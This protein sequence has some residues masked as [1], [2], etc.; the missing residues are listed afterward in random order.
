MRLAWPGM[1]PQFLLADRTVRV[2]V[3]Y[4]IPAQGIVVGRVG[5][6]VVVA[7][8][9]ITA[10]ED[11]RFGPWTARDGLYRIED[12]TGKIARLG[13]GNILSRVRQHRATRV[14][15]PQR[16]IVAV[17]EARE[18][19]ADE[20]CFLEL[21]WAEH[22]R[23]LGHALTSSMFIRHFP[24]L[25]LADRTRLDQQLAAIVNL[26]QWGQRLLDGDLMGQFREDDRSE[27]PFPGRRTAIYTRSF[28]P[29]T[30]LR[31]SDHKITAEAVV[32]QEGVM[33]LVGSQVHLTCSKAVGA[34]FGR[35]HGEFLEAVLPDRKDNE[36]GY[37][38]AATVLS[39]AASLLKRVTAGRNHNADGWQLQ[40]SVR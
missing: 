28:S 40:A 39:T 5:A 1:T 12:Q 26:A 17:P 32:L 29:G 35:L 18:W 25:T 20:R 11:P 31:F 13:Q 22:W 38:T 10:C 19:S 6:G 24:T 9:P 4:G 14:V 16:L 8:L 7:M 34:R 33:L 15:F 23:S 2:L 30:N 27:R 21:N 3:P 36:T 37:T